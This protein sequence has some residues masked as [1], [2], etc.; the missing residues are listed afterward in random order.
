MADG[1][2]GTLQAVAS[3]HPKA[4]WHRHTVTGP[5]GTSV[6]AEW[7]ML[8]DNT[9][10]LESAQTS[11]LPQMTTAD[12]IGATTRGLGELVG[13]ALDE[14]AQSLMIGLGGSATTDAGLGALE[15]LGATMGYTG[16]ART[17]A[18]SVTSIDTG[19]IRALPAGG[20]TL[21]TDTTVTMPDAP[22]VFGPQ[23][24]ASAEDVHLLTTAFNHLIELAGTNSTHHQPGSGAA[25]ATAWGL[26]SFLGA[27]VQPGAAAIAAL[28][29]LEEAISRADFVIT[30]EGR[31]DQTSLQGKV[32]GFVVGTSQALGVD[33]AV[34]AGSVANDVDSLWPIATLVN[35]A[36]SLSSA[37][38]EPARHLRSAA[39]ELAT[40]LLP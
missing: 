14:G 1:G 35:T 24:G 2:E 31:F 34:I 12:P 4:T 29:G 22:R 26:M 15:A 11:G 37:I 3:A 6:D 16:T 9:A 39:R 32:C 10:V 23:K 38:S 27:R 13:I 25:G 21:L 17:G 18:V 5:G 30:G 7:L 19:S 28:V 8:P 40:E 20:M 36:G 33:G